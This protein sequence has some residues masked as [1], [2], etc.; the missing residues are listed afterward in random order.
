[1]VE[2]A[3][4]VHR[5]LDHLLG[6]RGQANVARDGAIATAND[7]LD[8]AADLVQ[9]DAQVA[10]DFGSDPFSLTNETQQQV[11]GPDVVVVEA[12][13]LLLRKLQDFSRSLSK[14]VE[15]ISHVWTYPA[16][17]WEP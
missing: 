4:L 16:T 5:Q 14:F 17:R 13:R 2:S 10:E 9:L 6:A 11:L 3:R 8:R 1:M 7:E 12:L 15:A